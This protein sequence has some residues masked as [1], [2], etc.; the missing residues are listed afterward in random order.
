MQKIYAEMHGLFVNGELAELVFG[1]VPLPNDTPVPLDV[2]VP[3]STSVC[4]VRNG[5]ILPLDAPVVQDEASATKSETAALQSKSQPLKLDQCTDSST[6]K[7]VRTFT[8]KGILAVRLQSN[9]LF[10]L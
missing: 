5:V 3:S 1:E 7:S 2:D 8:S 9:P 4:Q 6:S 10:A